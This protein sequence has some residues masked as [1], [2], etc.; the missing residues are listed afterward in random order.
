MEIE[1]H[2]IKDAYL[3]SVVK[4]KMVMYMYCIIVKSVEI[5]S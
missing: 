1:L 2:V 5:F 3:L 4:V